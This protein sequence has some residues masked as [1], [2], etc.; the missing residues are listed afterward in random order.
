ME[1]SSIRISKDQFLCCIN[2]THGNQALIIDA[3]Q[4]THEPGINTFGEKYVYWIN[5]IDASSLSSESMTKYTAHTKIIYDKLSDNVKHEN[6]DRR[7]I[8]KEV[9]VAK[10]TNFKSPMRTINVDETINE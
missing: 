7:F 6:L 1:V 5:D 10:S 3:E 9:Y 4:I 2:N 8:S